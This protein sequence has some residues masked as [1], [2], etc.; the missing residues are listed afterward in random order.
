VISAERVLWE[1]DVPRNSGFAFELK[2]ND[3]VRVTGVVVVDFV[4]FNLHNVRERFDQARTKSN[5][6][7]IFLTAGDSLYSKLNNELMKIEEDT[8][9]R[10]R[11]DLQYGG[12]S[13]RRWLVAAERGELDK[14]YGRPVKLEDLPD[15]GCW[16]NLSAAVRPY[17]I[18]PEDVPS[19]FNIF[20]DMKIDGE[21]GKMTHSPVRATNG[22]RITLRAAMDVL[23]ALSACPDFIAGGDGPEGCHVAVLSGGS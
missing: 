5:H 13:H 2:K 22:E 17:G 6:S 19:P 23:V 21:T 7:K 3:L 8:F 20:Q 1:R 10:G 14:L 16:E 15:H 9:T 12:C 4:V 18:E 11:H